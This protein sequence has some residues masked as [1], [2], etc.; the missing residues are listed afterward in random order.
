MKKRFYFRILFF[1]LTFLMTCASVQA[2][3]TK[4]VEPDGE[5]NPCKLHISKYS[6]PTNESYNNFA[7]YVAADNERLQFTI[8][9]L[10]ETVYF[11][12]HANAVMNGW[13]PTPSDPQITCRI[14]NAAGTVVW[15]PQ[16]LP[17]ETGNTGYINTYNQ[18]FLGP[19]NL[20]GGSG[21]YDPLIFVPAAIGDYYIEFDFPGNNQ[22]RT[23]DFFDITIANS[24]GVKIPGRVWSKAWQF[25]TD[26]NNN[27]TTAILYPYSDDGITTSINL[28]GISPYRFAISCNQ[29]GCSNTGNIEF[30]RKSVEGKHTYPQ[31]RIFLNEPDHTIPYFAIGELG[32]LISASVASVD[33]NGT[34]LFNILTNVK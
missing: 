33:C 3:G 5:G 9:T 12:F 1:S 21:G 17:W 28:N 2:E 32:Q 13:P 7:L 29:T 10:N 16:T 22:S 6:N 15:G 24:S 18:A 25:T 31:Y 4:E 20:P 11:G 14:K 34:V 26:G 27:T 23:F 8:G 30:D 19:S